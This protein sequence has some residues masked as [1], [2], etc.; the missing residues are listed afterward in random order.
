MSKPEWGFSVPP[1]QVDLERL[2]SEL[3]G[4]TAIYAYAYLESLKRE[5]PLT[6]ARLRDKRLAANC[7]IFE[8]KRGHDDRIQAG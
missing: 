4:L 7:T 5:A 3:R 8:W 2:W 6:Y 1:D